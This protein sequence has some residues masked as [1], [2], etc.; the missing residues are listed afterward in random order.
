MLKYG[1][2][3]QWESACL[4]R[5]MS[6]VQIRS[7]P[8]FTGTMTISRLE[9]LFIIEEQWHESVYL[10]FYDREESGINS[11]GVIWDI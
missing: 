2:V 4:A 6:S 10:F 5:R 8:P 9:F 7:S 1:D 11:E 3:A